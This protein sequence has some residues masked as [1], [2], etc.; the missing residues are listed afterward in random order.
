M[1]RLRLEGRE[2]NEHD[3]WLMDKPSIE[4]RICAICGMR[5]SSNRHHVVPKS[6]GGADGPTIT[7]CG[8]GNCNGCHGLL[9]AH[10][11]HLR[12]DCGWEV[13]VTDEP[14]KYDK[15]LETEGWRPIYEQG[16]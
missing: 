12:Y 4:T 16:I 8:M 9:H 1:L 5:Q 3:R 6:R 7:V 2:M 14:M 11:A 10:K 15:A 13:L